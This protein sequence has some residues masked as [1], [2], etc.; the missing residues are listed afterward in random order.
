MAA[1]RKRIF[2]KAALAEII[3]SRRKHLRRLG[4]GGGVAGGSACGGSAM[5]LVARNGGGCLILL[6]WRA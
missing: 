5:S 1:G 6:G 4:V 3:I 2:S